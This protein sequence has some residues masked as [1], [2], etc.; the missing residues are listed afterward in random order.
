MVGRCN[1]DG[2]ASNKNTVTRYQKGGL[3]PLFYIHIYE[4]LFGC[5]TSVPG[6]IGQTG[7]SAAHQALLDLIPEGDRRLKYNQ[8]RKI[9]IFKLFH[10]ERG[11]AIFI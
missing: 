7:P 5:R 4:I 9:R 6:S 1:R 10:L 2:I 8:N 11:P 3:R